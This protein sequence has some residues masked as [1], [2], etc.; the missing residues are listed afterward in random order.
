MAVAFVPFDADGFHVGAAV[1]VG[2]VNLDD[3]DTFEMGLFDGSGQFGVENGV[4]AQPLVLGQHPQA[5]DV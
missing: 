3:F 2:L 5:I 4:A 1:E